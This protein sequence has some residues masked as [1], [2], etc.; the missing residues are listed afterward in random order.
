MSVESALALFADADAYRADTSDTGISPY[1]LE[2]RRF[3]TDDGWQSLLTQLSRTCTLYVGNL[4]FFTTEEQVLELFTRVGYVR[5]LIIG[6]NKLDKTPCG[7]CFVEYSTHADARACQR[8][9]SGVVNVD[10]RV[11]RADLDPGFEEGRQFGRSR[12][13]GGQRRDDFRQEFDAG[14]GGWV[15]ERLHTRADR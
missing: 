8:F 12:K 14:R 9:I 11:V 7:F 15:S 1:L 10:D 2:R 5:R 6:L 3:Y 4:S 13:S